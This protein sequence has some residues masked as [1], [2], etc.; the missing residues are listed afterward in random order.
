M[1]RGGEGRTERGGKR[2][3]DPVEGRV[4]VLELKSGPAPSQ[5][6]TLV[7]A[8]SPSVVS[9]ADVHGAI[10]IAC[11]RATF[12]KMPRKGGAGAPEQDRLLSGVA[13]GWASSQA[14]CRRGGRL[15]AAHR[16][17]PHAWHRGLLHS[18]SATTHLCLLLC[19]SLWGRSWW[20]LG[21]VQVVE[22]GMGRQPDG[23]RVR[24]EQGSVWDLAWASGS[25]TT[26]RVAGQ[27]RFVSL[28]ELWPLSRVP[29]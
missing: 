3:V 14:R 9:G 20:P 12:L 17:P 11:R 8:E 2:Q 6:C 18:S 22:A 7:L 15:P 28:R 5:V 24:E 10:L 16:G 29:D 21:L 26:R 4:W 13:Y 23:S 27:N 1:D 25:R 19:H